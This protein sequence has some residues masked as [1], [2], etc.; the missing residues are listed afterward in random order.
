MS[1]KKPEQGP[2]TWWAWAIA[3]VL[4]TAAALWVVD[5]VV[6][7]PRPTPRVAG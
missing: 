2:L 4:V 5:Q 3:G 1:K 6:E 7:A